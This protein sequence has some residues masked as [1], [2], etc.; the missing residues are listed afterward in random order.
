M[1]PQVIRTPGQQNFPPGG[2]IN[3]PDQHGSGNQGLGKK[4]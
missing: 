3:Q 2:P 1:I 4:L